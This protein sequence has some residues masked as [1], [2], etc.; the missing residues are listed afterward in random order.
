MKGL[1][2]RFDLFSGTVKLT[3]RGQ[4]NYTT[5]LGGA[6]SIIVFFILTSLFALRSIEHFARMDPQTSMTTSIIEEE[7]PFDLF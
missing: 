5:A 4:E 1:I 7:A 2:N 6:C 3:F